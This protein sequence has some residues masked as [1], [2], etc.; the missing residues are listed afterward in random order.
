MPEFAPGIPEGRQ[1]QEFPAHKE[2]VKW[3]FGVQ[4]HAAERAGQHFD[5]RLGDPSTGQ[6]H[7]WALRHFPEPGEKRLAVVQPTHTVDY[8]DFKGRIEEGY[9]KGDVELAQ[10]DKAEIV[11]SSKGHVRFNVYRGRDVDEYLLRRPKPDTKNWLLMNVTKTRKQGP[12]VDIPSS[13]PKYKL[14]K[15]KESIDVEDP[16]TELQAKVDGAHAIFHFPDTGRTPHIYSFRPRKNAPERP[17]DHTQKLEGWHARK[18]P[19]AIKQTIL[20]G[21]LYAVDKKG[22]AIPAARVGGL[23]NSN[24]W[25][26]REDQK[27]KGK[28][29]PVIFDVQRWRGE[30]V[31]HLPYQDK[32][33]LLEEAV[34]AAPWLSLPRT[35]RTTEEKRKLIQDI[36]RGREPSTD[37]GVVEWDRRKSTPKKFKFKEEHDVFV[38]R[39]FPEEGVKR[40]GIMAG[41]FEYSLKP[42]GE[43]VGRVGT[44]FSH[45]LKKDMIGSPSKYEGLRARVQ[46]QRAADAKALRSPAFLTFHLDEELPEDVKV[47]SVIGT[48]GSRVLFQAGR[49]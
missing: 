48:I 30:D 39:I 32:K 10:R 19:G 8:M 22:K 20:R 11:S 9:G 49:A 25:K 18:T 6:A 27:T 17:I 45:G 3:E 16:N 5:L 29:V 15:A 42:K 47:A 35:A 44:G 38:R 46:A 43:I 12:G 37:E 41:G 26:S 28:L 7:S 2:P 21:E 24:V 36:E 4:R 14:I 23:L 34:K 1:I 40:K 13:K 31:S 33:L